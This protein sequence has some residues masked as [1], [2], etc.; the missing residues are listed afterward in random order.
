MKLFRLNRFPINSNSWIFTKSLKKMNHHCL[1]TIDLSLN[2]RHMFRRYL[3]GLFKT[4]YWYIDTFLSPFICKYS[5]QT[6]FLCLDDKYRAA[7]G[8]KYFAGSILI[9]ISKALR[10]INQELLA[11]KLYA[12]GFDKGSLKVETP[13]ELL[14]QSP[15]MDKDRYSFSFLNKNYKRRNY[16]RSIQL[17]IFEQK[18]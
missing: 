7:L 5:Y 10:T 3:R 18:L 17:L 6:A 2:C 15:A 9:H 4:S 14:N 12:C 1:K 11:A 16:K 8:N 13:L